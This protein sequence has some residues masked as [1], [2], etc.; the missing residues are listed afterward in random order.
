MKRSLLYLTCLFLGTQAAASNPADSLHQLI[1]Q[2]SHDSS[3]IFHLV[4][5]SEHYSDIAAYDS[6]IQCAERAADLACH[7]LGVIEP[8][9]EN[10]TKSLEVNGIKKR[11]IQLLASALSNKALVI[12]YRGDYKGALGIWES[13]ML[14]DVKINDRTG[15]AKRTGNIGYC[16]QNMGDYPKALNQYLEA[17]RMDEELK[18]QEGI[19]HD[20]T[21]LG[22]N[23]RDL[24]EF[25]KSLDYFFKALKMATD[26]GNKTSIARNLGS[27]G[28]V[29]S[30]QGKHREALEYYVKALK[31]ANEAGDKR[32]SGVMYNNIGIAYD[33]LHEFPKA[34]ENY[35]HS[36]EIAKEIGDPEG[37]A[38]AHSNISTTEINLK[39]YRKAFDHIYRGVAI[40]DS[41]GLLEYLRQD[42][43]ILSTLY[44]RS[45]IPLPDTL[46]GRML[47]ME[48]MRLRSKFYIIKY[49]NA[50]DSAFSI[51]KKR[52]I[53]QKEVNYEFE[54]KEAAA[55]ALREQEKIREA[56]EHKRQQLYFI[57]MA[58]VAAGIGII[59]FLIFRSLRITRSQKVIIEQQKEQVEQAKVLVEEKNKEVMD[60]IYY[61]RRIQR[62][63][64]PSEK[65]IQQALERLRKKI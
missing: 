60:S 30:L 48:N 28:L 29:Y 25:P 61:A 50:R 15:I 62:A 27:I 9:D 64:L 20:F 1:L 12:F 11:Y 24:G 39:E 34:L 14:L 54:K 31:I 8:I 38:R 58:A 10:T 6:A 57:L 44:E 23:Y 17:L 4:K 49:Y 51:Q 26:Q 37:I 7:N 41:L 21:S 5:L 65:Y 45:G 32:R 35:I 36:L 42:Y 56:E 2:D 47:S 40:A 18:D 46:G 63:L 33:D 13:A 53:M 55:K 43:Y 22:S 59:A 19:M 16:Y 52:E 3:R